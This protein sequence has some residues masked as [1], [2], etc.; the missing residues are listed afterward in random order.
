MP[1]VPPYQPPDDDEPQPTVTE[2]IRKTLADHNPI[3][4]IQARWPQP[5]QRLPQRD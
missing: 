3:V 4:G 2:S 5:P 1:I